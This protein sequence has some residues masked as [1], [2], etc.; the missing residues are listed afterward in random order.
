MAIVRR[1]SVREE[2]D[3]DGET[4]IFTRCVIL[5]MRLGHRRQTLVLL[6]SA[7]GVDA[8]RRLRVWLRWRALPRLFKDA[9]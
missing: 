3:I 5:R 9:V 6:P 4:T 7:I 1:S 8:H 2:V